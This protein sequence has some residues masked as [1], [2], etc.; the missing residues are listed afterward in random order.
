MSSCV[1]NQFKTFNMITNI[2]IGLCHRRLQENKPEFF[3]NWQENGENKYFF[4]S[5]RFQ[6][7]SKKEQLKQLSN[8]QAI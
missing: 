8:E 2:N 4:S 6:V 7:E 1:K 3:V 5:F